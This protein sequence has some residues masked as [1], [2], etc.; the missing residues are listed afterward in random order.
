MIK[1]LKH[2]CYCY[3]MKLP[4][5]VIIQLFDALLYCVQASIYHV[6][7]FEHNTEIPASNILEIKHVTITVKESHK[8]LNLHISRGYLKFMLEKLRDIHLTNFR[9]LKHKA[10][11]ISEII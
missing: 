3:E 2:S 5:H 9:L 7:D 10:Y 8:K 4:F 6:Q 11:A 1:I